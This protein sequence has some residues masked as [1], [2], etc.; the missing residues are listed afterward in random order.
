MC[1]CGS[2]SAVRRS[3][4]SVSIESSRSGTARGAHVSVYHLMICA[5]GVRMWLPEKQSVRKC[6]PNASIAYARF[7]PAGSLAEPSL[8][9]R[10]KRSAV[11]ETPGAEGAAAVGEVVGVIEREHDEGGLVSVLLLVGRLGQRRGDRP[12]DLGVLESGAGSRTGEPDPWRRRRA[13]RSSRTRRRRR[14]P[15]PAPR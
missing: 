1:V 12:L 2:A 6:W 3:T 11:V 7:I 9:R 15:R 5:R 4:I 8:R 13:D 14:S 10:R